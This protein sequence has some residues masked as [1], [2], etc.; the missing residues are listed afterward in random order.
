VGTRGPGSQKKFKSSRSSSEYRVFEG[1]LGY[2][3]QNLFQK[4]TNIKTMK[5][6]E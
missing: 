5:I 3:F 4:Q 2:M 6:L 1:R